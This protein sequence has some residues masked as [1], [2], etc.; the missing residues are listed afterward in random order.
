M[1]VLALTALL[2]YASKDFPDWG[3]AR[4]PVNQ[5]QVSR[6]YIQHTYDDTL[7]PNQV[8]AILA[9]YRGYD[10][11][12]E[13]VVVLIA[14]L[15]IF[16]ILG[17]GVERE[18]QEGVAPPF[19]INILMPR[20]LIVR[21]TSKI[22]VPVIQLFALYVVAHGH[23]SPGG[24]FQ[25]GVILAASFIMMELTSELQ[26]IA[27]RLSGKATLVM[28]VIGVSIYGGWGLICLLQGG[29]FLD[30]AWAARLL[31]DDPAMARSHGMLIVEIGVALTVSS[32]M[33][34]IFRQLNSGG[35]ATLK[36]PA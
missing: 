14:G 20:D 7:V 2:L 19:R 21:L 29:H 30:Y 1:M 8:T 3:T 26:P 12:F 33:L 9:D 6:Y 17:C 28:G 35:Y 15:S 10:T 5:A 4:T 24:G 11:M 16:T 27:T 25:G 32:I 18:S 13:T 22:L 23:H 31:P 34:L 36:N